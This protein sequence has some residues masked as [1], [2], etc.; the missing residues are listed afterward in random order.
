MTLIETIGKSCYKG[1]NLS[2]K[3]VIMYILLAIL[4]VMFV[5]EFVFAAL[6]IVV[7]VKNTSIA[8]A[9]TLV[10]DTLLYVNI[11]GTLSAIAAVNAYS[12]KKNDKKDG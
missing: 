11:F 7:W 6:A 2:S 1:D 8:P 4:I 10:F 9:F 12:S 5:F 3:R